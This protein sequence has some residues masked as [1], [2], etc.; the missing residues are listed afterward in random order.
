MSNTL[1]VFKNMHFG[2]RCG[3]GRCGVIRVGGIFALGNKFGLPNCLLLGQRTN[4]A[5]RTAYFWVSGR[6][7]LAEMLAFGSAGEFGLPNCLLLRWGTKIHLFIARFCIRASKIHLFV[8]CFCIRASK[9]HLFVTRFCVEEATNFRSLC[10]YRISE[11]N[12]S[13]SAAFSTFPMETTFS[14][15]TIAGILFKIN[16]I[17]LT[18]LN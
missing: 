14:L 6:I 1:F 11:S 18:L 12:F 13:T 7:R 2:H 3:N 5:R 15:T 10:P 9:I 8:A 4:S 16:L 17:V